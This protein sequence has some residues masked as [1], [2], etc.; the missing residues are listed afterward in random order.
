MAIDDDLALKLNWW[1]PTSKWY[2]GSLRKY[3]DVDP[4][5][6]LKTW[7]TYGVHP[8]WAIPNTPD[9]INGQQRWMDTVVRVSKA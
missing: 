3:G 5:V 6:K 8:N 9:P 2:E 4:D 7:K 1:K